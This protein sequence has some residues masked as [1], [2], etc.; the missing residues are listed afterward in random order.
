MRI[1]GGDR[2]EE[3]KRKNNESD[4]VYNFSLLLTGCALQTDV[5]KY[6]KPENRNFYR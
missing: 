2:F 4:F 1:P 3:S 6:C 5:A